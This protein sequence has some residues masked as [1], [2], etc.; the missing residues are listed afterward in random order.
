MHLACPC[1]D[2]LRRSA[3]FGWQRHEIVVVSVRVTHCPIRVKSSVTR[4]RK[5]ARPAQ[6]WR[7][8]VEWKN[9]QHVESQFSNGIEV[10]TSS[11]LFADAVQVTS[12]TAQRCPRSK[13][14]ATPT[15]NRVCER[16]LEPIVSI[17]QAWTVAR[18]GAAGVGCAARRVVELPARPALGN[19]GS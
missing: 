16:F 5:A 1:D 15:S 18:R 8:L 13:S 19:V 14:R 4:A 9:Q 7:L 2:F 6:L 10:C 12:P 17:H 11:L 3:S